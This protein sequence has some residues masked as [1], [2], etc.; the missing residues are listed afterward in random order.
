MTDAAPASVP[1]PFAELVGLIMG[2]RGEGRSSNELEI[3]EEHLN[4]N[5]VVHGAV[6]FAMADT[7]MGSALTSVLDDSQMCS[8]I[9]IKI[10]YFRPAVSGRLRCDTRVINRGSRTA[11]LE[12]DVL[13]DNEKLVARATGTYMILE[14]P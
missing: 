13:D 9:E 6:I 14:R 11:A 4:P 3:T 10:N 5:N 7:G 2:E 12:S 1:H 8:T